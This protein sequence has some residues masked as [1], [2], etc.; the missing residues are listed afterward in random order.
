MRSRQRRRQQNALWQV[1]L[2]WNLWRNY[3]KNLYIVVLLRNKYFRLVTWT[4][5]TTIC[6]SIFVFTPVY[7]IANPPFYTGHMTGAFRLTPMDMGQIKSTHWL[8]F[9]FPIM[10]CL[11]SEIHIMT[12]YSTSII[13]TDITLTFPRR[14]DREF[15]G[16]CNGI[17]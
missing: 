4:F 9:Q 12:S 2:F 10:L 7:F 8:V 6:S 11:Q 14:Q 1:K 13:K 17:R 5:M 16:N 3:S 15:N